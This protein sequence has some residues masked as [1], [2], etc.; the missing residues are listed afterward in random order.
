MTAWLQVASGFATVFSFASSQ[1]GWV[2]AR[3]DTQRQALLA[4]TDGGRRWAK[5]R[6]L[7]FVAYDLEFVTPTKGWAA[8]G[9]GLF[10]TEDGGR[11]WRSMAEAAMTRVYPAPW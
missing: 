2:A 7:E 6:D 8:T 10:T 4:T 5:L 11:T 1:H 3:G 9:Q